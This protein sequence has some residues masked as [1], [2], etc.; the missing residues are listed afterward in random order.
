MMH[1]EPIIPNYKSWL[2]GGE[3]PTFEK[4]SFSNFDFE[5]SGEPYYLRDYCIGEKIIHSGSVTLDETEHIIATRLWQNT[6]KVHF[7]ISQRD[8]KKRLIYG[9]HI[10]F[11]G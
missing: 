2:E 11:H 6:S 7:D 5:L 9:G 3:V 8:D 4:I 10:I 1:L